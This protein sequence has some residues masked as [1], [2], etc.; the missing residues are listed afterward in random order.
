M[1]RATLGALSQ[2]YVQ[3]IKKALAHMGAACEIGL[4]HFRSPKHPNV[5]PKL[6]EYASFLHAVGAAPLAHR[7]RTVRARHEV[8]QVRQAVPTALPV[9]FRTGE[10][11]VIDLG[12]LGDD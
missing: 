4:A 12:P 2:N 1:M 3:R 8:R 5:A 11:E 6:R 10:G 9:G 7:V